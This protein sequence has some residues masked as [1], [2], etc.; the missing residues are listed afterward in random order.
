MA[1]GLNKPRVILPL[2]YPVC[3]L[4]VTLLAREQLYVGT[5]CR[6]HTLG[7]KDVRNTE[8]ESSNGFYIVLKT[9]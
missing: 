3:L 7:K 2:P 1:Q 8:T 6:H 4:G 9:A 5:K